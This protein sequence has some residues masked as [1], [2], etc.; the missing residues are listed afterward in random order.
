MNTNGHEDQKN[1]AH[2]NPVAAE[3]TRP[4]IP[5]PPHVGGYEI[6]CPFD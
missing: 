4:E 6:A 2:L 3:V 1:S 5:T